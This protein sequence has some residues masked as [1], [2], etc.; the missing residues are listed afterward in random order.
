MIDE[1]H[2]SKAWHVGLVF[3][4]HRRKK[5]FRSS[6][7][8]WLEGSLQSFHGKAAA[9]HYLFI[10]ALGWIVVFL[11]LGFFFPPP[12]I[13]SVI[14][15]GNN[16]SFNYLLLL[17]NPPQINIMLLFPALPFLSHFLSNSLLFINLRIF[18]WHPNGSC[19]P[20]IIISVQLVTSFSIHQ[21]HSSVRAAALHWHHPDNTKSPFTCPWPTVV[22]PPQILNSWG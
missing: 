12:I 3:G 2:C 22:K 5:H 1:Q 11:S 8:G 4:N 15:S 21:L 13:I 19:C 7:W 6:C 18:P 10:S 9:Q 16:S 17:I 20:A 14:C